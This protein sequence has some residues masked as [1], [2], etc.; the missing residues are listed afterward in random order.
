VKEGYTHITEERE[1]EA[2]KTFQ[3]KAG[4]T[5]AIKKNHGD[6]GH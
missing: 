4:K 1:Q 6:K 2:L 5:G 3:N